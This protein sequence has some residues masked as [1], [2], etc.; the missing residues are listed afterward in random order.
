MARKKTPESPREY[1]EQYAVDLNKKK[2]KK[3]PQILITVSY[4]NEMMDRLRRRNPTMTYDKTTRV[5]TN[6]GIYGIAPMP[7]LKDATE[8]DFNTETAYLEGEYFYLYR[9]V[10]NRKFKKMRK[11]GIYKAESRRDGSTYFFI[12]EPETDEEKKKY[13]TIDNTYTLHNKSIIDTANR[14]E[15]LLVA[16]PE[17]NKLFLPTITDQDDLLKRICK[18]VIL[19]KHIDLDRF[20]DRFANKNELFN[21][22]QVIRSDHRVSVKIFDR[23]I[24]TMNLY[25]EIHVMD[26]DPKDVVGD[27]LTKPMIVSS[28]G[29]YKL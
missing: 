6:D 19:E 27:K 3:E 12:S 23:F 17:S 16:I 5:I 2:K 15:D 11:P 26:R 25:Y 4:P 24:E 22:K 14:K 7:F 1:L 20:K 10:G 29:T 13:R 21:L 8:E 9:G 18:E 28:E